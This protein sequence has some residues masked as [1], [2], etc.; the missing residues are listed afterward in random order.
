MAEMVYR[1][2]GRTGLL[3]SACCLGAATFG[4]KWGPRWTMSEREADALVGQA[5]DGGVNFIDTANVYNAGE[6]EIWL[7]RALKAHGA[8]DRVVLSTKFGYRYDSRNP[9]SGGATRRA[10]FAAVERSLRRLD[11]DHIDLYYLHLWD[12]VTPVEET[13]SAAADLV[14]AGKI[15]YFGL[16]NVPGWYLGYADALCRERGWPRPAAVQANYNLLERSAEYEFFG[17][18]RYSGAA[19]VGWGPLANGLL[20]GRYRVNTVE[21]R[22][23][24]SGRLTEAFGTGTLDPFQQHLPPVLS[25]LEELSASTGRTQAQLALAWLLRQA[26]LTSVAVGISDA[27][28]LSDCLEAFSAELPVEVIQRLDQVSRRPTPYP[29]TFLEPEI[30]QLVHPAFGIEPGSGSLPTTA[31]IG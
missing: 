16:S 20:A 23:D 19:V 5:L 9:N 8:R 25:A 14:A 29:Y 4:S 3:V 1:R 15:R 10:M 18:A 21:R 22:L 12:N 11:T 30:Q 24:G 7:G 31:D 26:G 13:L 2:L 27:D 17:Y 28:Q 6:S